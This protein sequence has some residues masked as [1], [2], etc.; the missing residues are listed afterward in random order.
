MNGS[1]S[2]SSK[3][4]Q[5]INEPEILRALYRINPWWTEKAIPSTK[6][7]EFK[8]R[9]YYKLIKHVDEE[10]ITEVIGA[11]RVGKT[12]LLYQLIEE[13]L[14]KT[15]K[16]N[17]M[18]LNLDDLS[19]NITSE[20]LEK[21]FGVYATNIIKKP[22]DEL[23]DKIYIILDEVQSLKNWQDILKK[24]FDFGYKIKFIV[25]GSSSIDIQEDSSS[26]LVGRIHQQIVLPMKFL[27]FVRFKDSHHIFEEKLKSINKELREAL[28]QSVQEKNPQI[29][30][31]VINNAQKTLIADENKFLTWLN[32]YLIKGGY[33]EN[34][35][36]D[37][38]T[39]CGENLRQY[40][41]MTL[42]KDIIKLSNVRDPKSLESLF[43]IIAKNSSDKFNR[44][45]VA[46]TL[47]IKRNTTLNNY[48][49][50]LK[51]AFL[52]SESTF[53]SKSAK[54]QARRETKMYVNDI[55]IRNVYAGTFNQE[56]LANPTELGTILETIMADH[57]KRLKFNLESS[58]FP[59]MYYWHNGHEVDIVIEL[60]LTPIPFEIKYR[61]NVTTSELKGLKKFNDEFNPPL[62]LTITKNQLEIH[63]NVIFIPAWL[64]LL[65]C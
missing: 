26:T 23:D 12:T 40:L 1:Q 54:K 36:I 18:I 44:T 59:S 5:N 22:F 15:A 47:G 46:N 14:S 61:E 60:F 9:D 32:E 24:W 31:S 28:K 2:I 62:A 49:D 52:I 4:D 65:M 27:E 56:I 63:G 8:R 6:I 41:Y 13:L 64:Y 17:I 11:R 57:T 48:I 3:N 25:S 19:L 16:E 43:L 53:Y 21:I 42:Y 37:D 58:M 35:G 33:P 55:G 51:K 39:T 29:F 30:Y 45:N 7:K 38:L 10:K 34:V 20:N 50:L